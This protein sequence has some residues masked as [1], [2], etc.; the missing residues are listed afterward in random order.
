MGGTS[1]WIQHLLFPNRLAKD[2][3][4]VSPSPSRPSS[5]TL[6]SSEHPASSPSSSLNSLPPPAPPSAELLQAVCSLPHP[7]HSLWSSL[8]STPPSA[9]SDPDAAYTLHLLL[10]SLDPTVASRWHWKDTRKVLRSLAI[11]K[12]GGRRVSETIEEQSRKG[13]KPRFGSLRCPP[14]NFVRSSFWLTILVRAIL[15]R[16]DTLCFWLYADPKALS[17]RLDKRV[18]NMLEVSILSQSL[19]PKSAYPSASYNLLTIIT[20]SG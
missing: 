12:D 19:L 7:L 13:A 8:P 2:P 10:T 11:M 1:Y 20:C 18:D 6:S 17:P 5:P 4:T 14:S 9:I 16:Y 15:K 3:A